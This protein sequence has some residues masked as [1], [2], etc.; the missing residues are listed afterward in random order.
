MGGKT[1]TGLLH[2]IATYDDELAFKELYYIYYD[3]L[4]RFAMHFVKCED[5]CEE[6]VSDVFFNIW[7]NRRQLSHIEN[8]ES[9]LFKAIKNQS[10]HYTEKS[11]QHPV[12]DE[13]SFTMEYAIDT[14]NPESL[15]LNDELNKVLQYAIGSLPDKCRTI[16]KLVHEDGLPYKQIAEILG[17]SVR[18]IDAQMAIATKKIRAIV[19][20]YTSV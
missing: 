13:L 15:L 3:R 8:V 16:F 11:K 19:K 7:Q 6:V 17:I 1:H 20:K 9:Y 2:R 5:I 12:H 14:D 18:T 4:F 10:L